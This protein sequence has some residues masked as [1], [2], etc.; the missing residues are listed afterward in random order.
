MG[1]KNHQTTAQLPSRWERLWRLYGRTL[2]LLLT[3]VAGALCPQAQPASAILQY[4][5]MGMLFFSFLDIS[6]TRKSF[7]GSILAVFFANVAIPLLV[8][9]LIVRANPDL[10]LAGFITAIAP[11]ATATP[12]IIGFLRG[13]VEYVVTAVFIS[14]VGIALLIP[15][16]LPLVA[17]SAKPVSTAEVLPP[18]LL[19]MFVPLLLAGLVRRLPMPVQSVFRKGKPVTFALW[20]IVLF[21]VTAKASAFLQANASIP[22]RELAEIALLSLAT[23]ALNFALGAW[24]GG[25]AFRREASQ[26]LGQKNNSFTIWIAL[27]YLNPLTALGPTFYVLYHNLYNGYQLVEYERS[28][29]IAARTEKA[30]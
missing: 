5:L 6:I 16:L 12:V 14:N 17:G 2:A 19:V 29:E 15:F 24:I 30:V 11:T 21:I 26:A 7:H 22:I 28:E 27:T 8:Y 13:R 1:V 3:M 10:A 20:L 4:L 23:C 9:V 18:V 25:R